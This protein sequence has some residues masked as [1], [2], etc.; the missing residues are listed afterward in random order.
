MWCLLCPSLGDWNNVSVKKG[1]IPHVLLNLSILNRKK[2]NLHGADW[3]HLEVKGISDYGGRE[4]KWNPRETLRPTCTWLIPHHLLCSAE[5]CECMWVS[6]ISDCNLPLWGC[7]SYKPKSRL[8]LTY[9]DGLLFWGISASFKRGSDSHSR[10][11]SFVLFFNWEA[12]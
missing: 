4:R 11:K 3:A 6:G 12:K 8:T 7:T 2:K 5:N 9:C 10:A 1:K